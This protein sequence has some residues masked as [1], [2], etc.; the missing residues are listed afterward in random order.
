MSP[1]GSPDRRPNQ[2]YCESLHQRLTHRSLQVGG[3]KV[4]GA[5]QT[6]ETLVELARICLKQALVAEN[7]NVRVEL[8]HMAAAVMNNGKLQEMGE[9]TVA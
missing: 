1:N 7:K 8:M 5:M 4:E 9:A 2:R 3:R 6:Y